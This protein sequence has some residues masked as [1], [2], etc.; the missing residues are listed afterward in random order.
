[1]QIIHVIL[2]SGRV[3]HSLSFSLACPARSEAPA[4]FGH[5]VLHKDS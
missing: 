5:A 2:I 3:K 4:L 1:M